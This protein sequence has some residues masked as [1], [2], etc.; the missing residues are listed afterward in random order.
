ML[1]VTLCRRLEITEPEGGELPSLRRCRAKQHLVDLLD[2]GCGLSC[3]CGSLF[4]ILVLALE[5]WHV[6]IIAVLFLFLLCVTAGTS[7]LAEVDS[8]EV[9]CIC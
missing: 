6:I 5:S 7:E 8:A 3:W 1:S 2:L 9:L 4:L